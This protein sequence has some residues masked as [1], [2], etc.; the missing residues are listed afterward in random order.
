MPS[1]FS[2]QQGK[3]APCAPSSSQ[4][5]GNKNPPDDRSAPDDDV[6]DDDVSGS[7]EPT[8]D[9]RVESFINSD[10]DELEEDTI[11][12]SDTVKI[13]NLVCNGCG[14]QLNCSEQFSEEILYDNVSDIREM[15]KS[16]RDMHIMEFII[17]SQDRDTTKKGKKRK[18]LSYEYS[19]CGKRV[20]KTTFMVAFSIG[21][22]A[23]ANLLQHVNEHGLVPRTHGN[24]GKRPNHSLKHD[25]VKYVIQYI[26]NF[27]DEFGSQQPAA[28]RG[29]DNTPPIYL[30]TDN[31]KKFVHEKYTACCLSSNIRAVKYSTFGKIWN[32]CLPH[33][34]VAS[35]KDDVCSTCE[36]LRKEMMDS[37][38]EESKLQSTERMRQHILLAQKE[39]EVYNSCVTQARESYQ[40]SAIPNYVH[41]TFGYCQNVCLPHHSRQMGPVYFTTPRKIQIFGFRIDG[42]PKQLN[43]LIDEN[44]T[45]GRDGTQTSGPNSIISMI[46]WAL[47]KYR[48]TERKCTFHADNCPGKITGMCLTHHQMTKFKTGPN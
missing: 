46:D 30:P 4:N 15:E 43:F 29:R 26:S 47:E 9:E 44:E 27:A 39:R 2:G 25:E 5:V 48:G 1:M 11:S 36:K 7:E 34:K 31:S 20:C 35:L 24:S 40:N 12:E 23:L 45:I 16:Q 10:D 8:I 17:E 3:L 33:I 38:T 41:Y 13:Q 18:R 28:P 32:T 14:C 6:D 37:V 22:K 21:K 42:I 19:F